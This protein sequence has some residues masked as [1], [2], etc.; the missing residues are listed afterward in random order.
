MYSLPSSWNKRTN[1]SRT[2]PT[3]PLVISDCK[4]NGIQALLEPQLRPIAAHRILH[5]PFNLL[6]LISTSCARHHKHVRR[7]FLPIAQPAN[8]PRKL[9][10]APART[11]AILHIDLEVSQNQLVDLA[12]QRH[13]ARVLQFPLELAVQVCSP[14]ICILVRVALEPGVFAGYEQ[15]HAT[16]NVDGA[17]VEGDAE[18]ANVRVTRREEPL[19]QV[20]QRAVGAHDVESVLCEVV[21]HRLVAELLADQEQLRL[22]VCW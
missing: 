9:A 7:L 13:P 16:L 8:R 6:S 17:V 2:G 21:V 19:A 18:S 10:Q 3:S 11:V 14:A 15:C 22:G 20:R 12:N 1:Q 4:R 5:N